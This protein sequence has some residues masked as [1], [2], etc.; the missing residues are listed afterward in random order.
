MKAARKLEKNYKITSKKLILWLNLLEFAVAMATSK[1]TGTTDIS[2]FLRKVNV[3]L[4]KDRLFTRFVKTLWPPSLCYIRQLPRLIIKTVIS[5]GHTRSLN[6]NL[7]RGSWSKVHSA[8]ASNA[9]I[10]G[11][12]SMIT[13][14]GWCAVKMNLGVLNPVPC[15]ADALGRLACLQ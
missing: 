3:Q 9:S 15:S 13:R 7:P 8:Q 5:H 4:L 14:P 2:K 12:D 10:V 11:P 6:K 1:I